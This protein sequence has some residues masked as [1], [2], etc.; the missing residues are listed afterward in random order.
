MK[1]QF[2]TH[3]NSFQT[4]LMD[5]KGPRARSQH[6]ERSSRHTPKLPR[7]KYLRLLLSPSYP[8]HHLPHLK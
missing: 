6:A 3:E 7:E 2:R 4:L 8:L 1:I 5:N